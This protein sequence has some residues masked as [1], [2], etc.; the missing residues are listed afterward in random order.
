M[1]VQEHNRVHTLVFVVEARNK[2]RHSE[3]HERLERPCRRAGEA[4]QIEHKLWQAAHFRW[5]IKEHE[6]CCPRALLTSVE[7]AE[8]VCNEKECEVAA[9]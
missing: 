4:E 6:I 3:L 9:L 2:W 5:K 1:G 7:H 8:P